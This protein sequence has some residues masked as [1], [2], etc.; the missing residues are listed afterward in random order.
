MAISENYGRSESGRGQQAHQERSY[1][2]V[3]GEVISSAKDV[4][5]SEVNLFITEFKQIQPNL[6]KHLGQA[7]MFGALMALSILPF[8]AFLVIGLGELLDGRY[9]LSSLIVSIACAAIGGPLAARSFAKI[10]NEDFKFNQTKRSLQEAFQVTTKSI[11]KI[12]SAS[13]G[14]SYG[15]KSYN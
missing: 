2:S 1:G 4:L 8:L 9:W 15:T 7:V 13:K 10:K 14:N 5:R 6:T 3:L 12:K 11:E